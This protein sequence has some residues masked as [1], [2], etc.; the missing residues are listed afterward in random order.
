MNSATINSKINKAGEPWQAHAKAQMNPE[1][2]RSLLLGA[3]SYFSVFLLVVFFAR[4]ERYT[5]KN[6]EIKDPDRFENHTKLMER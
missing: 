6:T 2:K 5:K 4:F 1:L 3:V